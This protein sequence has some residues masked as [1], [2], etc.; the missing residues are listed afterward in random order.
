MA[1]DVGE[2]KEKSLL[3]SDEDS[4]VWANVC[5]RSFGA[6]PGAP[7]VTSITPNTGAN[8]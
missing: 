6:A 8:D 4:L 3:S 2:V 1:R 5:G 7:T